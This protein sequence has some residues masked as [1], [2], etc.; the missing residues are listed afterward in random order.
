MKIKNIQK[1]DLICYLV[2]FIIVGIIF[3]IIIV[4]I[5]SSITQL[6]DSYQKVLQEC[7]NKGYDISYCESLLN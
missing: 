6:G 4:L 3:L 1:K 2:G 5:V 7:V